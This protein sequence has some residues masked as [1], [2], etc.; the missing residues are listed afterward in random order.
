MSVLRMDE[1]DP[2]NSIL[3]LLVFVWPK[4]NMIA[5]EKLDMFLPLQ[6]IYGNLEILDRN[7]VKITLQRQAPGPALSAVYSFFEQVTTSDPV[8]VVPS[9]TERSLNHTL[10]FELSRE[11]RATCCF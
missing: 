9:L 7:V 5:R 10:I 2:R 3:F 8:S 1:F 6:V 11:G 4:K